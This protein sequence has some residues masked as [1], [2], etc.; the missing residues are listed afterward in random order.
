MQKVLKWEDEFEVWHNSSWKRPKIK[1][2]RF[3]LSEIV[4]FFGKRR[5]F[6]HSKKNDDYLS[7]KMQKF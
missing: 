4:C 5:S 2:S 6:K 7:L 1:Q 3:M